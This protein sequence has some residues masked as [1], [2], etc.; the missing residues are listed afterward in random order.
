MKVTI[1]IATLGLFIALCS[2]AS[3]HFEEQ[4]S[5][6]QTETV[7][8]QAVPKPVEIVEKI[9]SEV[10]QS[11]LSE[12]GFGKRDAQAKAFVVLMETGY[13]EGLATLFSLRDGD[14]SLYLG[15]GGGIIGGRS[16]EK[17]RKAA[18]DFVKESEKHL[19]ALKSTKEFPYPSVG[20]VKF[21]V[22]TRDGVLTAEADENELGE[23]KHPLS[24]LF[25]AGHEVLTQLRLISE[26]QK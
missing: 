3:T 13:P 7:K 6:P 15:N 25:Y 14:A 8:P 22:R 10:L 2:P 26:G 23:G 17:V 12:L 9:R 16:H 1:L 20:Q 4:A 21:Y 24:P 19:S 11:S 5:K 18:I